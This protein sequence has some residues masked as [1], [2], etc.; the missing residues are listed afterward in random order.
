V[1]RKVN[2]Q[3]VDDAGQLTLAVTNLNP[4]AVAKLDILRDGQPMTINVTLGER[5]TNIASTRPGGG[6]VQ[7]G[8]LR[9]IEVQNLTPSVREQLGLPANVMGVVITQVDPN[10]PAAQSVEE[11]DVIESINRQ[12]VHNV[13]DFNR[14]AS[15]A[16][17]QTLL[18]VNHQGTGA[19]V[20]ISPDEG[21]G[22]GENQ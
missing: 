19:Y 20:V 6:S 4:G 15:Q 18:R 9:G 8:V 21:G 17:G 11:G 10:S 5:P 16:K 12:P 14:L 13:G 2:G 7:Q 3:T 22:G 1:I